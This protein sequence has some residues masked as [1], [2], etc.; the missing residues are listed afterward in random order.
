MAANIP[1]QTCTP[2]MLASSALLYCRIN[3]QLAPYAPSCAFVVPLSHLHPNNSYL[4]QHDLT[5]GARNKSHSTLASPLSASAHRLP[6]ADVLKSRDPSSRCVR[7]LISDEHK[8]TTVAYCCVG[9]KLKNVNVI[10]IASLE[11][12]VLTD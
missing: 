7:G 11:R 1:G 2:K 5:A 12:I 4:L 6:Q 8:Q 10:H 9:L 3:A